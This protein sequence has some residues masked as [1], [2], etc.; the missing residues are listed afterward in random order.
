MQQ[1]AITTVDAWQLAD[2]W[3]CCHHAHCSHCMESR[4]RQHAR[5]HGSVRYTIEQGCIVQRFLTPAQS[6][7]SDC[8]LVVIC[9]VQI[10]YLHT[11]TF[12]PRV[13]SFCSAPS[14]LSSLSAC[15]SCHLRLPTCSAS[16]GNTVLRHL[17]PAGGARDHW[18]GEAGRV[19][20]QSP[21]GGGA[22]HNP[23][24]G[25]EGVHLPLQTVCPCV[26][27]AGGRSV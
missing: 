14:D 4:G 23:A 6:G 10:R 2:S 8:N 9:T 7:T 11:V 22:A 27:A 12:M 18:H 20:G 19:G 5:D 26:L 17:R 15:C 21:G 24:E 16:S 1:A 3:S 25:A 13:M